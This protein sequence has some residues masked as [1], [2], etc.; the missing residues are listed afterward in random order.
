MLFNKF[1]T[2]E[3]LQTTASLLPHAQ[4]WEMILIFGSPSTRRPVLSGIATLF[5]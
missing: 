3:Y 1:Q 2:F 4:S 5:S